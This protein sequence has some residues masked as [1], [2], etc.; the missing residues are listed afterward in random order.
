[1]IKKYNSSE[2]TLKHVAEVQ[3]LMHLIYRGLLDRSANHDRSKLFEPEKPIFDEFVPKLKETVFGSPEYKEITSQMKVATDHHNQ[4]NRHHPE[5]FENGI[6]G[7][8][9]IDLVEMLCDWKAATK[10]N[11]D[12]D[13]K[14]SIEILQ[15]RFNYSD[16]LKAILLNTAELFDP[17]E[18]S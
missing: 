10:R 18:E 1:M 6:R 2:D 7:M 11:K 5:H 3:T 8:N 12:G 9:L 4:K 17:K 13:I 15:Q 14:K 16:D